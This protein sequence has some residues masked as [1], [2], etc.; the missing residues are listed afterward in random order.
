MIFSDQ[1]SASCS[2]WSLLSIHYVLT[3]I[4]GVCGDIILGIGFVQEFICLI[5][6]FGVVG[7][8]GRTQS[9]GSMVQEFQESYLT[10]SRVL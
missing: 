8:S 2:W 3:S 7:Y 6:V 10:A 4:I 1:G 5:V 9:P